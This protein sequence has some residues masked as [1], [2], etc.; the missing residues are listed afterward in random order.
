MIREQE[1]VKDE[2]GPAQGSTRGDYQLVGGRDPSVV[3][4]Q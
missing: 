2:K 4:P 3:F 1:V